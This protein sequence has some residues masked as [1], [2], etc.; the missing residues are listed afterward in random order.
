MLNNQDTSDFIRFVENAV[1][2]E[3]GG[4][5]TA[6]NTNL[7]RRV[8]TTLLAAQRGDLQKVHLLTQEIAALQEDT[9]HHPE[10]ALQLDIIRKTKKFCEELFAQ[11]A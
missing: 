1:A 11:A 2:V 3:I 4:T 9:A 7:I 10:H 8:A 5:I 6:E